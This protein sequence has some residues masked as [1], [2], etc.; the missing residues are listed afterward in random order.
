MHC[1]NVKLQQT[2]SV[3]HK[4]SSHDTVKPRHMILMLIG[5]VNFPFTNHCNY[6]CYLRFY[7]ARDLN[8]QENI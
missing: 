8:V 4:F 3:K 5:E 7:V 1:I 2:A 6:S